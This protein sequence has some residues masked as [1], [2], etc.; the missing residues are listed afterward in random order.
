MAVFA[1]RDAIAHYEQALNL[2]IGNWRLAIDSYQLQITKYQH[3]HLQLGRAYELTNQ[4]DKSYATYQTMLHL[5]QE[6]PAPALECAALNRLANLTLQSAGYDLK[7]AAALLQ[8]AQQVAEQSDDKAGL[9]ETAWSLAQ[10]GIHTLELEQSSVHAQQAVTL[11]RQ[12]D[13]PELAARS[14]NILAFAELGLSQWEAATLHADEGR[15]IYEKLGNRAMQADCLGYMAMALVNTGRPH[16]GM[17]AGQAAWS[18]TLEI[19]NQWGQSNRAFQLALALLELAE[20]DQALALSRR[21]LALARTVGAFVPLQILNLLVLGNIY[22]AIFSL[23]A[24]HATHLEALTLSERMPSPLF[25]KVVAAELCA[26]WAMLGAWPEAL[27]YA[28]QALAA[29]FNSFL[30][31]GLTH[32]YETEVLLWGGEVELARWD[33]HQF[34]ERFAANR[35]YQIPYLRCLSLLAQWNGEPAQAI[36]YLEAAY[37][38]AEQIG[39]PGEQWPILAKLG[40]L[41]QANGDERKA[42]EAMRRGAEIVEALAAKIED[43]GLRRG[44][45]TAASKMLSGTDGHPG[46]LSGDQ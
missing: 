9:A 1:V 26:D 12:L 18:I 2:L 44:F 40:E 8:Q 13:M 22:R 34:G 20:Y 27:R 3:L 31:G 28:R 14:L 39:L 30:H 11:A 41:Y 35:R 38:L 4:W 45:L 33:I 46:E 15:A 43:E 32:W 29:P 23:D 16:K 36:A 37:T 7:Q 10:L 6:L 42:G 19:E 17:K 24:A 21:G 25:A 5:A